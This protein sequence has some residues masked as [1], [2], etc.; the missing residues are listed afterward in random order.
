MTSKK[1]VT[2][3]AITVALIAS[4]WPFSFLSIDKVDWFL[5]YELA[6]HP[7]WYVYYTANYVTLIIFSYIIHQLCKIH[8]P[9]IKTLTLIIL[10][11][12]ILRLLVYWLFRGSIIIY[13]VTGGILL[14]VLFNYKNY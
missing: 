1:L 11:F 6:Q 2:L 3:L 4:W 10:I 12:T 7:K 14:Y 9:K 13:P 8:Y 5:F